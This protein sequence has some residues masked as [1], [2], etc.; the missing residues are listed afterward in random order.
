M[1]GNTYTKDKSI[2]KDEGKNL[3]KI[4]DEV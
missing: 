4:S 3:I 2:E 1:V